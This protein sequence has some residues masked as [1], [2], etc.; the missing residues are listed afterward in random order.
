MP[1]GALPYPQKRVGTAALKNKRAL[2]FV[3]LIFVMRAFLLLLLSEARVLL[4]LLLCP[5]GKALI[6]PV[7]A[8][9]YP[10]KRVGTAALK[11]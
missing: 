1:V 3:M 11:N 9:P 4:L 8:L 10:Q 5:E 7:G 2:I 6:V